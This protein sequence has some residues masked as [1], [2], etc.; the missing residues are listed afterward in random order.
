M[1]EA[2]WLQQKKHVRKTGKLGMS[3][4]G[5]RLDCGVTRPNETHLGGLLAFKEWERMN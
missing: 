2:G 4:K 5:A 3:G 1:E